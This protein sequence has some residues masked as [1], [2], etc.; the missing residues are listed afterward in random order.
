MTKRKKRAKRG[1]PRI[2]DVSENQ[3]D[4]FHEQKHRMKPWI[5]WQLKCVPNAS[6]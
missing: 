1:R 4:A 3:M 6:V 2:K 5:N